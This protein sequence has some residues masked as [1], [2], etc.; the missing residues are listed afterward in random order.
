MHR[1]GNSVDEW[2]VENV[3]ETMGKIHDLLL[4]VTRILRET[5]GKD[6]R[7]LPDCDFHAHEKGATCPLKKEK[8]D[9]E[10][11]S[12]IFAQR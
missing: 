9:N 6:P 8:E 4:D 2:K 11:A 10:A 7:Q 1:H 5:R 12:L 3:A